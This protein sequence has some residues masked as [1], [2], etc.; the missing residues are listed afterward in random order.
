MTEQ[1]AKDY[2]TIPR[3]GKLIACHLCGTV[4]PAAHELAQ[5]IHATRHIA[6]G[7]EITVIP[8]QYLIT[9]A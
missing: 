2:G 9:W 1:E 8:A 5:K 6:L 4:M 7:A 3:E